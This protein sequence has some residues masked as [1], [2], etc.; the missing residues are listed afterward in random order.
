MPSLPFRPRPAGLEAQTTRPLLLLHLRTN[1]ELVER[2][3]EP[4]RAVSHTPIPSRHHYKGKTLFINRPL[5]KTDSEWDAWL[6]NVPDGQYFNISGFKITWLGPSQGQNIVRHYRISW[7][8]N[9]KWR[10]WDKPNTKRR[11]NG[12]VMQTDSNLHTFTLPGVKLHSG[13]TLHIR[14]RI[15]YCCGVKGPWTTITVPHPGND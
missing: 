6:N 1:K 7:G 13:E 12:F 15:S 10:G 9:D 5:L 3:K 2:I 11:G 14:I 8:V 4:V